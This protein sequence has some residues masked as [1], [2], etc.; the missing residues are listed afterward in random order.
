MSGLARLAYHRFLKMPGRVCVLTDA[1][2]YIQYRRGMQQ[3]VKRRNFW[4]SSKEAYV[5]L[6]TRPILAHKELKI[7][8][9]YMYVWYVL[10]FMNN[11]QTHAQMLC[12]LYTRTEARDDQ[13]DFGSC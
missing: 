8:N 13:R 2:M 9:L 11:C 4:V 1:Y 10:A 3:D 12:G 5:G 7:E 6:A